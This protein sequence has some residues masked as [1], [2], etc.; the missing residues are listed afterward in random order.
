VAGTAYRLRHDSD[1]TRVVDLNVS[2]D[3]SEGVVK[4][5]ELFEKKTTGKMVVAQRTQKRLHSTGII[6]IILM[7]LY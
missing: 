1:V 7:L 3:W 2:V 6:I 4:A 5:D